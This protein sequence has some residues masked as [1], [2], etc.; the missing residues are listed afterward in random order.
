MDDDR[1]TEIL[2]GAGAVEVT[3]APGCWLAGFGRN[4]PA[5]GVHDP[6]WARALALQTGGRPA[7]ILAVDCL[8]L[9][10]TQ[11][12]RI[13]EQLPEIAPGRLLVCATHTPSGPDTIGFW[14]PD[15]RSSGVRPDDVERILE[16]CV[17][18]GRQALAALR[19]G[20]LAFV[21]TAAPERCAVNVRDPEVID[22]QISILHITETSTDDGIATL[23]NWGCHPETLQNA[24]RVVSSDFADAL[25]LRIE[26]ALGGTTLY[27]NGVLGAM[28]TVAAAEESSA[29]ADRIGT[30]VADAV[31]AAIE[32]RPHLVDRGRLRT[33]GK[34]VWLPLANARFQSAV[35]GG[36]VQGTPAEN[37]LVKSSVS[38]WSLGPATFL[39]LPGEPQPAVGKY[40][41]RLMRRPQRFLLSLC[42]DEIG[43]ILRRADHDN[44]LYAYE[45]SMA[46]G[47]DSARRIGEAVTELIEQVEG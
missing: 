30:A 37:D 16:G 14:G 18:A 3:P 1:G 27:V 8:G 4:R 21:S 25:R 31:V 23:V 11:V 44:P 40:L 7:L 28:V 32:D 19:P 12:A 15:E 2:A 39:G 41:K 26:A 9:L 36:Q 20:L 5:E 17:A 46:V 43:Y 13:A 42:N 24:S 47:P 10:A 38:A 35:E 34:T 22:E 6:L 29:E 45:A 33:V